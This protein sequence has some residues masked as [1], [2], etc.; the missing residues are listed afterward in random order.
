MHF[1]KAVC[2]IGTAYYKI[3]RKKPPDYFPAV[4]ISAQFMLS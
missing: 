2:T 3:I 1:V 4:N